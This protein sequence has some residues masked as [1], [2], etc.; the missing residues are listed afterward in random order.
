MATDKLKI[1]VFDLLSTFSD[2][3]DLVNTRL[4]NHHYR[5]AYLSLELAKALHL[6]EQKLK[7]VV[8]AGLIH[9]IGALSETERMRTLNFE[10]ENPHLHAENGYRLLENLSLLGNVP[11]IIR[12][13]HTPWQQGEGARVEA[14]EVP[15]CSHLLH[16]ADRVSILMDNDKYILHQVDEICEQIEDR[17]DVLFPY[18]F[19][20]AFLSVADREAMWLNLT[21]RNIKRVILKELEFESV[22][23]SF[24]EVSEIGKMFRR[25][26]DF[27]SQFTAY[28]STGVSTTASEL[29]RQAGWDYGDCLK[30][31]IAGQLHDLGKLSIPSEILEKE[32][33]LTRDEFSLMRSHTYYTYRSLEHLPDFDEINRWASYHHERLDG[34]GYPFSLAADD[35]PAGSR[36]MSI[37][38]VFTALREK[39]PYKEKMEKEEAFDIMDKM[40]GREKIDPD[41]YGLL[42][43]NVDSISQEWNSKIEREH[44][45][46]VKLTGK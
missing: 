26:I 11:E 33:G 14:K 7:D 40:A 45:E 44:P 37:A 43:E 6:S 16:L 22:N 13:H 12:F 2:L 39:R 19:V 8:Y 28:H 10:F 30:M 17:R 29:A 25:I 38:D 9:D 5:V 21:S 15:E 35:L 32:D 46:Y 27:R 42:K 3:A 36:M 24:K 31:K 41:L 20:E 34:T 18:R 1:T 4:T 23:L